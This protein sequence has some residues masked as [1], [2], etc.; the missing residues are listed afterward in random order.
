MHD[1]DFVIGSVQSDLSS[2]ISI[3]CMFLL[4]KRVEVLKRYEKLMNILENL[5]SG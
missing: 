3:I 4:M 2:R 1:T 5:E